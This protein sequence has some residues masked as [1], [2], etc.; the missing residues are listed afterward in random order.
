VNL[1]LISEQFGLELTIIIQGLLQELL[2]PQG[3]SINLDVNF[4]EF[5]KQNTD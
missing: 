3:F 5:S 1:N 4:D 2:Y